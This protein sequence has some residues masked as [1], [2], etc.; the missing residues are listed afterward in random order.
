MVNHFYNL[1]TDFYEVLYIIYSF[2][3][4]IFLIIISGDGV[5]HFI[6]PKDIKEK[7]LL[8]PSKG[9]NIYYVVYLT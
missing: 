6:L 1:V 4:I 3:I 8:N 7:P 9:L 5:N 2:I